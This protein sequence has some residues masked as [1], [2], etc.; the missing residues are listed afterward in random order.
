MHRKLYKMVFA[1]QFFATNQF[2]FIDRNVKDLYSTMDKYDQEMFNFDVE[3]INWDSYVK[4][5]VL[6]LR[7]YLPNQN[8][9]KKI[10]S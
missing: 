3:S 6:G 7:K 1:L 5:I 2:V 4:N 9:L 10:S 8:P